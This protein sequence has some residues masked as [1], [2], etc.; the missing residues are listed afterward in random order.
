MNRL[1]QLAVVTIFVA[2]TCAGLHAQS[3]DMRV[4]IPFDFEAGNKLMP[5]GEYHVQGQGS[6]II[7][8]PVNGGRS[9]TGMLTN[10]TSGPDN[11]RNA[12]LEFTRYG[13]AY[14]LTKIWSPYSSTG[15]QVP[16]SAREK[17][18]AK[19]LADPV[20]RAAILASNK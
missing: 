15:R 2:L 19:R 20:Q 12:R 9:A 17:E 3:A 18:L 4:T 11:N 13:S 6:W 5:A 10:A 7:I 8:R 1:K 16:Q 14:F